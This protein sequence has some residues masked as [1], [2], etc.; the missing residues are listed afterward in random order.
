MGMTKKRRNN[1]RTA[2]CRGQ[3]RNIRCLLTAALVLKDKALK[4]YC[5]RNIVHPYVT[6]ELTNEAFNDAYKL[7]KRTVKI[8][9]SISAAIHNQIV[10]IH[11]KKKRKI[12]FHLIK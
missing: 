10:C 2:R 7:P 3:V 9:Y 8:Y 1:G 6:R 12:I 5:V 4:R 11:P